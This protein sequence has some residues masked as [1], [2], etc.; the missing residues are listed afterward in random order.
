VTRGHCH[1]RLAALR[2]ACQQFGA[3]IDAD[4]VAVVD[5]L[6]P[7]FELDPAYEAKLPVST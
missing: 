3:R 2:V 4:P 6:W 1:A 5:R 7:E